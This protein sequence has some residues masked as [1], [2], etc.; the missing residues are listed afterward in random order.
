MEK[1]TLNN[2]EQKRLLVM[3]EVLAGRLTGQEAAEELGLS[4]RHTRRLIAGYRQVGAAAL[5]HGN[6]GR[7]P[8]N[9]LDDQ[10]AEEIVR[11]ATTTLSCSQSRQGMYFAVKLG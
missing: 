2:K 8:A 5:A 11:L 6:R 9:K 7:P 3:N 10:L 1:V 4:L